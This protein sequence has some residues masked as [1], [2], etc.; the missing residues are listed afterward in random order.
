MEAVA[1][2]PRVVEP[3]HISS[4]AEL[5]ERWMFHFITLCD[6]LFTRTELLWGAIREAQMLEVTR[7]R[8]DDIRGRV[9]KGFYYPHDH[10]LLL[11]QCK[12][13]G[14]IS[15]TE[16]LPDLIEKG[17]FLYGAP[18]EGMKLIDDPK[19]PG[20]KISLTYQSTGK[21]L[22][23]VILDDLKT[24]RYWYLDCAKIVHLVSLFVIRDVWGSEKFNRVFGAKGAFVIASIDHP[25]AIGS[26]SRFYTFH[27]FFSPV[28]GERGNRPVSRGQL[29]G[30]LNDPNYLRREKLGGFGSLNA[31]CLKSE[32]EEKRY[33]GLGLPVK[34]LTEEE[35][36]QTLADQ[37]N[38]APFTK[39]MVS[40]RIWKILVQ[41][42]GEPD[43]TIK[44]DMTSEKI[45]KCGGGFQ[46]VT[47]DL[48]LNLEALRKFK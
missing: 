14:I 23:S 4:Q 38:K 37:F 47:G 39:E 40:K 32:G 5:N 16:M 35:I 29:V 31:V 3:M 10:Y 19:R 33:L 28:L 2:S 1:S 41:R 43:L 18:P 6:D 7:E 24:G 20:E 9:T 13:L 42:S 44:P 48:R 27:R 21:K 17:N 30:F 15:Q 46:P 8:R 45:V 34:G 12:Q 36:L 22:P 26:V 25:L 11:Q